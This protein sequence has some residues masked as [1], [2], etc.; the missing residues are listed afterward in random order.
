MLTLQFHLFFAWWRRTR[1]CC[2]LRGPPTFQRVDIVFLCVLAK[3][4]N[5]A[6]SFHL[7]FESVL[8]S[9]LDIFASY[10][11]APLLFSRSAP[12]PLPIRS[13]PD[14]DP[15]LLTHC[16]RPS[17]TSF[18]RLFLTLVFL[19]EQTRKKI[20][21][22]YYI[23]Q[24]SFVCLLF[25]LHYHCVTHRVVINYSSFLVDDALASRRPSAF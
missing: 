11:I 5:F 19:C 10:V 23:L 21:K 3:K 1:N 24:P 8:C 12:D 16:S 4:K 7:Q 20:N 2:Q 15:L 17:F 22:I 25:R 14:P 9:T 6:C 13:R 18:S